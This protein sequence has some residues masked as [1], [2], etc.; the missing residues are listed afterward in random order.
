M[1]KRILLFLTVLVLSA[2]VLTLGIF[3]ADGKTVYVKDGGT[4]NGASADAPVG[5][6]TAAVN[7]LGGKG[8]KIVVCGALTINTKTTVPE[9]SDDLV[10]TAE[11]GGKLLIKTRFQFAKN[12]NDNVI[13]LDLPMD[14][15]AN[16]ACYVF[17]GFN[18]I[19]FTDK[20]AVTHSGGASASLSFY[21]GVLAS[22]ESSN[23]ACIATLPYS[24][25]VNGGIFKRFGGG[26]MRNTI[27]D[28]IGSIAAP[29]S[30]TVNGGTFGEKDSYPTDSNNKNY[31]AFSISGMSILADNATLT[32]N[33]GT[34]HAPVYAQGRMGT[35]MAKASEISSTTASNKKYYAIDG[36]IQVN[37]NGGTFDGGSIGAYYTQAAYTQVM[38]GN[39]TVKITGTPDFKVKTLVDATQVK[40]Y[41]GKS[42]KATI[43][44]PA[45]L[46]NIEVKRFDVVNG[47]AKTYEE[48]LRV[49]FIG[50]SIT[51]GYAPAAAGVDRLTDSYPANFLKLAEADGKEVILSNY[52]VSASGL[53]KSASRLYYDMLAWPLV[54]EETDADYIFF[55]I[56]TNDGSGAGGT[57]GALMRFESELTKIA[58][59]M[60][61]LPDTK[62]VFINNAIYRKT[63]NLAADIRVSAVIHPIQQ[64]VAEKLAAAEPDKYAFVDMYGLTL[65]AAANESLFRDKKG[66][67]NERLHPTHNG[68]ALM[69]KVCYDAAFGGVTKPQNDYK[70]TDIYVS[71]KGSIF[72]AGTKAQPTNSLTVAFDK[73]PLGAEV[74]IHI[75][76]T[77]LYDANIFFP[78]TASKITLVGEGEGAT[79]VC[80]GDSFKIGPD[81]KIDNLTLRS[82]KSGGTSIMACFNNF[83]MTDT[84]KTA[85]TWSFYA[86][87]NVFA[88]KDPLTTITFDT[89]ESASSD[90]DCKIVLNSGTFVNFMLGNR[91]FHAGAPFGIYSGNMTAVIGEK[92]A[93]T[94]TPQYR[95]INGHDYLTGSLHV[96][97][98]GAAA[99]MNLQ[100]YAPS[101]TLSG[102]T[103]DASKHTG[104][105]TVLTGDAPAVP[106][107]ELKMTLGKTDYTVNGEKRTMDVAPIIRNDRTMLPV[108]YVAEALGAEILWD[109]ATSTATL[110]TDFV[111]IKLVVGVSVAN[112]NG[113]PVTLDAAPFIENS[114]T[115]MPVRFVAETLGATV[116]WDGA[117]STATITK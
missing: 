48:P 94:G 71:S 16:Y 102:V 30:I 75:E 35:V 41:A 9:Q 116:A 104:T 3:A 81:M 97:L 83:E 108:R 96:T 15:A 109:G 26:N 77:I 93:F 19:V 2:F 32:I 78:I 20:V 43:T 85:G 64:R 46:K 11:N 5:T 62:K 38:R 53:T 40:A 10:I 50:D 21:G 39:Y 95:A 113:Q 80:S 84:V 58:K 18:N 67:I 92:V 74:T 25:T 89:V 45:S 88:D 101:G 90:K 42:E 34:F 51:E 1:K 49:A 33:G 54:S 4:G 103:Y 27:E 100:K 7:A 70:R 55:A 63:S 86:G 56:G 98:Q 79:L 29:V 31:D 24:I 17:G 61:D 105:I 13:T 66:K 107:V 69:G 12:K 99:K 91:R 68:L 76:G 73:I 112:V 47:K 22:E 8:G 115:Y 60:G 28:F 23:S 44:Y 52:G 82:T 65:D 57:H 110:K 36:D 106:D 114:R 6:M 72:G 37:I 117:T 87:Y 14:I 59:I 111:T